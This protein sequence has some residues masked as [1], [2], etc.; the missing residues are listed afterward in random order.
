MKKTCY[1]ID[2][3]NWRIINKVMDM[4]NS[5]GLVEYSVYDEINNKK[6]NQY[7]V[8]QY[9]SDLSIDSLVGLDIRSI[10]PN[11]STNTIKIKRS[12]EIERLEIHNTHGKKLTSPITFDGISYSIDI[13]TL[14]KDIYFITMQYK[15]QNIEELLATEFL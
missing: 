10:Y 3:L 5:N 4:E 9:D 12:E 14:K 2:L 6:T 1:T 11:P 7:K 8:L 15:S 13:S